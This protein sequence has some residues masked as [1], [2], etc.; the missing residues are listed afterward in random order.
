VWFGGGPSCLGRRRAIYEASGTVERYGM[1]AKLGG[2]ALAL[3]RKRTVLRLP[4][5]CWLT[6]MTLGT[7]RVSTLKSR[8]I[9]ARSAASSSGY[10]S[11]RASRGRALPGATRPP[12]ARIVQR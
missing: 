6:S 5:Y 1:S 11:P 2:V 12:A 10:D 3:R 8:S 9:Q 7:V 4:P